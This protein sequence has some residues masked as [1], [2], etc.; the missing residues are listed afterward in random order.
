MDRPVIPATE[1]SEIRQRGGASLGPVTDVVALAEPNPAA[2]ESAAA[3]AVVKRPSQR[4]RDR[5]GLGIDFHDPAV[6]AVSH[7]HPAGVTRKALGRSSWNARAVF[8]D[9]LAGV[10]PVHSSLLLCDRLI[11]ASKFLYVWS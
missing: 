7:H 4:R 2:R 5:P 6:P 11:D 10:E 3:V 8:E 1:Q 9:G